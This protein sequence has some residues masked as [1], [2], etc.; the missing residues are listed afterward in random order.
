[1]S[2]LFPAVIGH[3]GSA[4]NAPENTLASLRYAGERGA[5]MVEFDAKLTGD[6]V[7]ILMHDSLL[8]RTTNGHGPVAATPWAEIAALDAGSWFA[9]SWRGVPVPTLESAL[10]L[11]AELD[12]RANIEIKAC[13]GREVETAQAIVETIRAHWSRDRGGLFLSSF[14]REALA[15]A[16]ENAPELPRGLLIWEKPADWSAA[17]AALACRAVHC[18]AQH[19]T[20]EWAAEIKRLGY[21]LA[22][23]TVNDPALAWQLRGWGVDG[24]ITDSPGV[25]RAALQ[26]W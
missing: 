22:V 1:M 4:A 19:L 15:A 14:A 23:Y 18:A 11:L 12:L 2:D 20:P 9:D 5:K 25:L 17:A 21:D 16:R 7:V 8:D 6:G 10:G 3:R 26:G 13:P 24:I